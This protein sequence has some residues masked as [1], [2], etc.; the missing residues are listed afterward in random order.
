MIA[1]SGADLLSPRHLPIEAQCERIRQLPHDHRVRRA[2]PEEHRPEYQ[3]HRPDVVRRPRRQAKDHLRRLSERGAN[4]LPREAAE[5]GA[6]G[7]AGALK[8]A[9]VCATSMHEHPVLHQ[10]A[11]HHAPGREA[12]DT[13]QNVD[14]DRQA[15]LQ[16]HD[17]RCQALSPIRRGDVMLHLLLL[18]LQEVGQGAAPHGLPEHERRLLVHLALVDRHHSWREPD[19]VRNP[20]GTM[21]GELGGLHLL[22]LNLS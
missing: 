14:E 15:L 16:G 1:H 2:A 6:S 3:P 9:D 22:E 20:A 12:L 21:R 17:K 18:A 19:Q 8:T 11:M 4:A 5:V 13:S 7:H 10:V